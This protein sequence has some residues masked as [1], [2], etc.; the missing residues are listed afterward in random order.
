MSLPV[1]VISSP[2]SDAAAASIGADTAHRNAHLAAMVVILC[3]QLISER[4]RVVGLRRHGAATP[5]LVTR[6]PSSWELGVA[7]PGL[8]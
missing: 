5:Q 7:G 2:D 4:G 8:D 1:F 3:S 6:G